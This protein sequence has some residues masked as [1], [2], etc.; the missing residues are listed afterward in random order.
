MQQTKRGLLTEAYGSYQEALEWATDADGRPMPLAGFPS[1]KLGDLLR[2][3]NDLE[4]ANRHLI[5]G[6]ELCVQLGQADVLADGY[7]G[8]ARLQLARGD[9]EGARDSLQKGDQLVRN[10][11]VDPWSICWLD[12]CRL[13]LWISEGNL[14]A[15]IRWAETG[16]LRTDGELS[17]H[18]DLHHINLARVLVTQGMQQPSGPYLEEALGLLAR[19]LEAAEKAGW[20]HEAIKILI[21][22]ALALRA[23]DGNEAA[24]NTLAQALT[25]AEPGGYVRVFVDEG[26]PIGELLRRAA[27]RG[28]RPNYAGNLLKALE[29][30][31]AGGQ[32]GRPIAHSGMAEPLSERELEV[33]RLLTTSLTT[34]EIA[35]ELVVSVNTVRSHVKSIYGK[36]G[37]HRRMD[38]VQRARAFGLL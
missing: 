26:A 33:L 9:L 5:K 29:S 23:R 24:L 14:T 1:V 28:I 19:L 11:K 18:H 13:R 30:D 2:E 8:L 17:Y 20:I 36:L 3:R 35:D 34:K 15:A 37:V 16:E 7:V 10:V 25:L 12:E 22:K 31:S 6:V 32:R 21:M 27:A 4:S 38:A